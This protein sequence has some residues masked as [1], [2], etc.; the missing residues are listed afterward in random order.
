MRQARGDDALE[1]RC[2]EN[3]KASGKAEGPELS[4]GAFTLLVSVRYRT[5]EV[6]RRRLRAGD[7]GQG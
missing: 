5:G 7:P 4:H 6:L 2:P 1:R 3:L